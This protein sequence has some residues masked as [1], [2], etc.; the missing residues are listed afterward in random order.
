ML[1][2]V[3]HSAVS[4]PSMLPTQQELHGTAYREVQVVIGPLSSATLLIQDCEIS[5]YKSGPL[6]L[7][8]PTLLQLRK[9]MVLRLC[10]VLM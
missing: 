1:Q 5:R 6:L 4:T 2:A 8:Q 3:Q 7:S 9:L 10:C